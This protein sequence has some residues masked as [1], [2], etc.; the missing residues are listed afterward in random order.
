MGIFDLFK[1]PTQED[2]A[3]QQEALRRQADILMS[4]RGNRMPTSTLDAC[5]GPPAAR[6]PGWQ[7]SPP[8][9]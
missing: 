4:L 1:K 7:P 2:Q 3:A 9:N 5:K 6:N 8:P